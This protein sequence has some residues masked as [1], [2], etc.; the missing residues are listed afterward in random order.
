MSEFARCVVNDAD[1]A[2]ALPWPVPVA[3]T[4]S[5][6]R[7]VTTV[8]DSWN[9]LALNEAVTVTFVSTDGA[10][11]CQTSEVPRLRLVRC[12]SAHVRPEPVT[13]AV[14]DATPDPS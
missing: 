1:G 14:C 6:P 2:P 7:N 4:V 3:R 12:T 10:T 8:S 9:P 13:V 5:A 11:A